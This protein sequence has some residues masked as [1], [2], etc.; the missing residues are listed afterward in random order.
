MYIFSFFL[1]YELHL[2]LYIES[3]IPM[4]ILAHNYDC[5]LCQPWVFTLLS[6]TSSSN[7][8]KCKEIVLCYI[9]YINWYIIIAF[10][11]F[12]D[13]VRIFDSCDGLLSHDSFW[14]GT[15]ILVFGSISIWLLFT[16]SF[17]AHHYT[18]TKILL[19]RNA[20]LVDRFYPG[21]HSLF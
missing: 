1:Y 13:L 4:R 10:S 3:F 8:L 20:H 9:A 17:N 19:W 12:C 6:I 18:A 2:A 11:S 7:R 15:T 14:S 16:I 21:F 5:T